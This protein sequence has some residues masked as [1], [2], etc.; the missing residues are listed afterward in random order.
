[1]DFRE[2]Y[3]DAPSDAVDE[4]EDIKLILEGIRKGKVGIVDEESAPF[5]NLTGHGINVPNLKDARFSGQKA[6]L[7]QQKN[8]LE[9]EYIKLEQFTSSEGR[10]DYWNDKRDYFYKMANYF[11]SLGE[12]NAATN[13][14]IRASQ[15]ATTANT[16]LTA[17]TKR[18]A[19]SKQFKEIFEKGKLKR[20]TAFDTFTG[21]L[22]EPLQ[23]KETTVEPVQ[24]K[25]ADAEAT[26]AKHISWLI[27]P[28][29]ST[30]FK[31][32]MQIA[33]RNQVA[34]RTNKRIHQYLLAGKDVAPQDAREI[35]EQ[36]YEVQRQT[37]NAVWADIL[38]INDDKSLSR[39]ERRDKINEAISDGFD[40]LRYIVDSPF[41]TQVHYVETPGEK[42]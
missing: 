2:S 32:P 13:M 29:G 30:I 41:D 42:K 28:Q 27:T 12:T 39:S 1:M 19:G 10:M 14:R 15:A 6:K 20:I 8:T 36:E 34:I 31:M 24:R 26:A 11:Q 37:H 18:R 38:R 3:L 7:D 22:D 9:A 35:A 40:I 25:A 4:M 16:W 21:K 23:G 17:G 33:T 5:V